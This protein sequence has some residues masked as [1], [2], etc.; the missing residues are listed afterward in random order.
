[1]ALA[2]LVSRVL[3]FAKATL[4]VVAIGGTASSVGG[5]AFGVANDLPT[6][7]FNLI[8][9]GVL[10]AMIFP[11]IMRAIRVS[12]HKRELDALLTLCIAVG[13]LATVAV[14]LAAPLLVFVYA[15]SWSEGWMK[16]ALLMAY[17]CLPQ[18]FFF[19]VYS[20]FGQLLNAHER[21]SPFAW[22]PAASNLVAIAGIATFLVMTTGG[23]GGLDAW[24]PWMVV[25]LCLGVTGGAVVQAAIVVSALRS[26]GYRYRPAWGYPHVGEISRAGGWMFAGAL[27]GQLAYVLTSM[28]ATAAGE[29][30]NS[31]GVDGASLNSYGLAFL[32][33]LL[34]H[35]IF[36]V[37]IVTALFTNA[38]RQL[39]DGQTDRLDQDV[40]TSLRSVALFSVLATAGFILLGP[41]VTSLVWGS[42][43]IG[44]VLI[45][46]APGLLPFSQT[47][48]L[49][50]TSIALR[51]PRAVFLTQSTVALIT[52]GGSFLSGVLLAPSHVVLG[53]AVATSVAQ[54][55]GWG[56]AFVA[57]NRR[58]RAVRAPALEL[59]KIG[60]DVLRLIVAGAAGTGAGLVASPVPVGG[61]YLTD[62]VHAVVVGLAVTVG[63]I[64]ACITMRVPG[65][66]MNPLRGS[67][68]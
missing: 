35:G 13:L 31:E 10:S 25:L 9:G 68:K 37:S 16:L 34:P 39:E 58:M 5:Q 6:N 15:P 51:D 56:V 22:A 24:T 41:A 57:V 7:I 12:G 29:R 54:Y 21:F 48:L 2:A 38:S 23:T 43:V 8:A 14:T 33:F 27:A 45:G 50:R 47:Y 32:L 55:A 53:I 52:G 62:L 40:M 30:L 60:V 42:P 3:G 36:S 65:F 11:H 63:F 20:V 28:S 4:L 26:I 61:D 19:I 59:S 1:M 64:L 17:L 18:L 66:T 46:L 44:T 67:A 49:N